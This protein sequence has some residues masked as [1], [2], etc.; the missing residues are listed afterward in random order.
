METELPKT[1]KSARGLII[2]D[3]FK[4]TVIDN[5]R[6]GKFTDLIYCFCF[7]SAHVSYI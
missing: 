6:S 5:V 4:S 1:K 2:I 7:V 3:L